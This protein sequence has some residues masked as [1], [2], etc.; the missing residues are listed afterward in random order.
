MTQLQLI[1]HAI[2]VVVLLA[3]GS[4]VGYKVRDANCERDKA[5]AEIVEN[6]NLNDVI[7]GYKIQHAKDT[8][9]LQTYATKLESQGTQVADLQQQLAKKPPVLVKRVEVPIDASNTCTVSTLA[10]GFRLCYNA[11]INGDPNAIA[12]CEASGLLGSAKPAAVPAH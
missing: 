8:E 2:V 3:L 9:Q 11:A 7:D 12:A 6:K 5:K 1:V 4:Y 10:P